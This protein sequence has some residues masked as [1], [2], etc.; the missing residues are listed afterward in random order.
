MQKYFPSANVL[1]RDFQIDFNKA[2]LI[3]NVMRGKVCAFDPDFFPETY[4]FLSHVE[5]YPPY[6]V[7]QMKAISE[8]L[9]LP[10]VQQGQLLYVDRG[11]PGKLT[12]IYDARFRISSVLEAIA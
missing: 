11:C 6:Q 8:V 5:T 7:I 10:L 1:M 12:L 4:E 3:R 9:K 2:I